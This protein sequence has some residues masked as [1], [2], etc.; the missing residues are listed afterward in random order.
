MNIPANSQ[1]F[2][3]RNLSAVLAVV[4]IV[5]MLVGD[6]LF[7]TA[8]VAPAVRERNDLTTRAIE[9]RQALAEAR[10][11]QA[12]TPD[13]LKA[14]VAETQ[15]KL[16][17]AYDL[18]L[19]EFQTA[20]VLN[21]LYQYANAS[22]VTVLDLQAQSMSSLGTKP[23]YNVT[24]ARLHIQG[25]SRGL[26]DFVSRIKEAASKSFVIDTINIAPGEGTNILTID[27]TLY[28]SPYATGKALT[29][30]MALS[31]PTVPPAT[32]EQQL[33]QRLDALWTAQ[34]WPEVIVV[35]EQLRA[36]NPNTPNLNEKLYAAH[37]NLGYR[38]IGQGKSEEAK[39]E[40]NRALAV[41]P[42]GS[43]ALQA[44][45]QLTGG[46]A[47]TTVYVVA[48]GD[49]LFSIARRYGTT[50]QAIQGANGLTDYNIRI[51]QQLIIPLP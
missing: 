18:L 25:P 34:S 26:I 32:T 15:A 39:A 17:T 16:T 27:V 3:Q 22:G 48:Q 41:K 40:F 19:T 4:L 30:G 50:V 47:R 36:I 23:A 46:A 51:G 37:V 43:E 31:N 6:V 10:Q 24:A 9:A 21:R 14:Q 45:Q 7:F 35:L 42:N 28:A 49:T 13:R 12:D 5:V 2:L 8:S 38:L 29:I 20:L 44:L 1:G 33:G 11:A